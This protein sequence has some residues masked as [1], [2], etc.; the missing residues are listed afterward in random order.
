MAKHP[1]AQKFEQY[2]AF[3]EKITPHRNESGRVVC[4][5]CLPAK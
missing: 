4:N 3:C 1:S 5:E 2:C